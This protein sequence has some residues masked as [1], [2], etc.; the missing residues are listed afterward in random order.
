LCKHRRVTLKILAEHPLA[1]LPTSFVTR[2]MIDAA[3]D[4]I[5]IQPTVSVQMESIDALIN[6][7][8]APHLAT[9]VPERAVLAYAN[10]VA[11]PIQQP[12]L[13]RHAGILWRKQASRGKAA[14]EFARVLHE[15]AR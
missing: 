10:L 11:I 3:F 13:T 5:G 4:G 1:L 8:M 12:S 9:I 7:C 14:K 2:R 6:T 15:H